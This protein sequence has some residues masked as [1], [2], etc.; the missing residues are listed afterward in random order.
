M[1][2]ALTSAAAAELRRTACATLESGLIGTW[3]VVVGQVRHRCTSRE[4]LGRRGMCYKKRADPGGLRPEPTRKGALDE[5]PP[6]A[7]AP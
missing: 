6:I 2:N 1:Q 3:G 7:P 4:F 5:G